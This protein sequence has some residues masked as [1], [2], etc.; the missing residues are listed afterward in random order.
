[1]DSEAGLDRKSTVIALGDVIGDM[2]GFAASHTECMVSVPTTLLSMVDAIG[3][4]RL[5][6]R[7]KT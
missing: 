5:I 7:S 4:K 2:T 6:F 3:G 1:M